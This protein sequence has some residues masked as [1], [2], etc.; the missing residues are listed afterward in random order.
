MDK[1]RWITLDEAPPGPFHLRRDDD[2]SRDGTRPH[3]TC[4]GLDCENA[5]ARYVRR[6]GT[7]HHHHMV[8]KVALHSFIVNLAFSLFGTDAIV[9]RLDV[10]HVALEKLGSLADGCPV[11]YLDI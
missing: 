8:L 4:S 3:E 2:A 10:R 1:D 7:R 11:R 9:E 6:F 5:T